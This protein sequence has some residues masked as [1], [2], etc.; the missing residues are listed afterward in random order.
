MN[1]RS[2]SSSFAV[3]SSSSASRRSHSHIP[4]PEPLGPDMHGLARAPYRRAVTAT[5]GIAA[6]QDRHEGPTTQEGKP[7]HPEQGMA[8]MARRRT[9]ETTAM[10]DPTTTRQEAKAEAAAAKARAK[11]LRP[12]YRKKRFIIPTFLVA[13][14]VIGAI[15]GGGEDDPDTTSAVDIVTESP[16]SAAPTPTIQTRSDNTDNPP[17][18]D[19]KITK[20]ADSSFGVPEVE[21]Q[22]TNHSSKRSSYMVT[23]AFEDA[24]NVK[25][26]D[27]TDFVNNVE[28]GQVARS[29]PFGT[30]TGEWSTCRITDVERTAD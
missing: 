15:A 20:C 11:A 28:P 23:I 13:L 24:A 22:V 21:I 2:S 17:G 26:G 4:S 5:E 14:A 19:V 10:S 25:A 16:A 30:A 18:D 9:R 29:Q 6:L 8:T 27:A 12:W 1:S 3:R 7:R